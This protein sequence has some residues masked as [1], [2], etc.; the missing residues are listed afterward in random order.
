M[1]PNYGYG[2]YQLPPG[3]G[4]PPQ[5]AAAGQAG[6][7][8]TPTNGAPAPPQQQPPPGAAMMP[9][10]MAMM[11]NMMTDAAAVAYMAGLP[12]AK[13]QTAAKD[14][15]HYCTIHP[16]GMP[17]AFDVPFVERRLPVC[18]RCKKNFKSRDLCRKRDGHKALPWQLTYVVITM[19][20]SVLTEPDDDGNVTIKNIPMVCELQD[21]P[22]MCLGPADGSMKSE[23]ICKVCREKNYTRDYCRNTCKHSTPPWSTTYVRLV[24]D[25]KPKDD[26][27]FMQYS[28]KKRKAKQEDDVDGKPKAIQG[29]EN[30]FANS[31][32]LS[33]VH[34]SKTFICSISSTTMLARWC[35]R[36][37]YPDKSSAPAKKETT[38]ETAT[39]PFSPFVGAHAHSAPGQ[40][41]NAQL[42]DA[43]RAG[44][45]WAQSQGAQSGAPPGMHPA[46]PYGAPGGA[47]PPLH[48]GN[49][50][51]QASWPASSAGQADPTAEPSP[52][53]AKTENGEVLLDGNGTS[54]NG[55]QN[56]SV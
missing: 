24:A 28:V 11:P 2:G 40:A 22:R 39:P 36:I 20:S 9:P 13:K 52:K 49:T 29:G 19:D 8:P 16:Q 4:F 55:I 18:D 34:K 7:P 25:N 43:F 1:N 26:D 33:I 37:T 35:E 38:G 30:P 27:R 23:P 47:P 12:A 46:Y 10:Q 6:A 14:V 21:T 32:D 54:D 48:M 3:Y 44:A 50:G 45:L 53:K 31:D 5:Q 42:W 51:D 17:R 15:V 56:V 41:N